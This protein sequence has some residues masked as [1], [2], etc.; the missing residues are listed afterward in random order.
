MSFFRGTTVSS[1]LFP[2]CDECRGDKREGGYKLYTISHICRGRHPGQSWWHFLNRLC[3][4]SR[5][6]VSVG[7]SDK[8][9]MHSLSKEIPG[10][11]SIYACQGW[12]S[13]VNFILDGTS[14]VCGWGMVSNRSVPTQLPEVCECW[15][16]LIS[17]GQPFGAGNSPTPLWG[18]LMPDRM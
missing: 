6:W 15:W 11:V 4:Q 13:L 8:G 5:E 17:L 9:R 7:M 1:L 2:Q 12:M 18:H 16:I 10:R 3:Q 14:I